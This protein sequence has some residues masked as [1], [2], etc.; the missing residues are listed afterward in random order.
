MTTARLDKFLSAQLNISR[1]DAKKLIAKRRV[2]CVPARQLRPETQIDPAS[3]LV[4]LD[5]V[6]VAYRAHVYLMLNKPAGVVSATRDATETTV[7]DLVPPS[8]RRAGLFPAG[9]LDKDT[10]G[11]VL[12]TDDGAFAHG[13]LSPAHHVEKAYVVTLE[14]AVRPEERAAIE[15]GMR[16]GEQALKPARLAPLPPAENGAPRYEIVLT[17][18]R[19]HQIRRMFAAFSNPVAALHRTR[20][21]GLPLDPAL[22]PGACRALGAEEVALLKNGA[23]AAD[24]S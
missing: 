4:L 18:G 8:L 7:L 6:A 24:P 14:R 11:F 5:G 23:A 16:L 15:G 9:R 12:L 19:Y 1:S 10:T 20:I 13:I 17:E 22:P 3:D 21:G 2:A